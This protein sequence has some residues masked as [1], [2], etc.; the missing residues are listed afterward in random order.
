MAETFTLVLKLLTIRQRSG[1]VYH[2]Q[3]QGTVGRANGTL[4]TKVAKI[5]ADGKLNWV[6]LQTLPP[7]L[8]IMRPSTNRLKTNRLNT[9]HLS[10]NH[11]TFITPH[12]MATGRLLP[13]PYLREPIEGPSLEGIGKGGSVSTG[14]R[15]H[16]GKGSR[17][18]REPADGCTWRLGLREDE[19]GR[20]SQPAD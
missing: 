14:E 8:M 17:D 18:S 11:L 9:N 6:G 13:V 1:S 5:M 12:E 3:S 15:C 20:R 2:P 19:H 7:A 4:K 10:T 16:Q